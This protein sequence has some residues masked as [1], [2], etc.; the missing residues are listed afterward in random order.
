M[1]K[2][3]V[4]EVKGLCHSMKIDLEDLENEEFFECRDL[5]YGNIEHVSNFLIKE[6]K[7]SKTPVEIK[8][9]IREEIK[10]FHDELFRYLVCINVRDY[11]LADVFDAIADCFSF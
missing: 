7:Y 11:R 3:C 5:L 4:D 9:C 8:L 2:L 6:Y 1:R 10:K